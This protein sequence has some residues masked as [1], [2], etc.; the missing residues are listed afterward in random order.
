MKISK[1]HIANFRGIK[2][3]DLSP[4]QMNCII[5]ENNAGKSTGLLAINLFLK[6]T[7]ISE[8]DFYEK[9]KEI[10]IDVT[11]S[12]VT[13][14]DLNKILDKEN[15]SRIKNIIEN[16]ELKFRRKYKIDCTSELLCYKKVPINIIYKADWIASE[17]KG[18]KG[19]ELKTFLKDTYQFTQNDVS[20]ISSQAAAKEKIE[21]LILN[22][23]S[24]QFAYD[25]EHLPTGFSNTVTPMFPEPIY[26]PAVKDFTDETKTKESTSFGKLVKILFTQIE[27][28]PEFL[29][30]KN[31]FEKLNKM[32]NRQLIKDDE[33]N[34]QLLDERLDSL[35]ILE[36][37]IQQV[38]QE[39]F[40]QIKLELQIPNPEVRQIFNSTQILVD[41]GIKTT[42]DYKGDGVK[43]TLVFSIL[44]TY[45][46]KLNSDSQNTDYI[47][48]F[49]E[50]EL[51]LH[52]NGQRIL[53]N[54]LEK[55][56]IKDQVFVTTHSP[57]FFSATAKETCFIKIYKDFSS[58]P[59]CSKAK[60]INF[61]QNSSYKDAFQIIC[62]E[63]STP[64][65]FSKKVLLVEGDSDLIFLKG[66]SK[67]INENYCFEKT[68][69]PIIRINGKMNTKRFYEFYKHFDIEVFTLL[70]L[71]ILI[72]G[73][74]KLDFSSNASELNSLRQ[75]LL[76][77]LDQICEEKNISSKIKGSIISEQIK[78]LS[79]QDKYKRLKALAN[80]IKN[81]DEV[82]DDDLKEIDELFEFETN[83]KRREAL[84]L[85]ETFC[86]EEKIQLINRL[87]DLG[88]F[89]LNLGAI[90]AYY[91]NQ[92][93]GEDKPSKALNALKIIEK[94]HIGYLP[95]IPYQQN[96]HCELS[97]IMNKIFS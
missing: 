60:E 15:R 33:G 72:D 87:Y 63:N 52:P 90:E 9:S 25:W 96:N 39:S 89:V 40:S 76:T 78:K 42:I 73:F 92:T 6:G 35:K 46:E 23:P 14:T 75:Q 74:D 55:L 16:N 51:Y 11:F 97:L 24:D 82:S 8:S 7:K 77:K 44:R 43:R 50:P 57:N 84:K 18:K 5:G 2:E 53:Y 38:F 85:P 95:K 31:S 69:I 48:L 30:I 47:F 21:G 32:L 56:S 81:R 19:G 88:Y 58:T 20:N 17:L 54:V 94:E 12:N 45:V 3:I 64:A 65:F 37:D 36:S 28:S 49:E 83:N 27:K 61:V 59:P 1:I 26:I 79:W 4:A 67:F 66:L 86:L 71:D 70:D 34:E 93:S 13:E 29:E 68:N 80:K 62:Y 41:D 91:P 22:L 10:F